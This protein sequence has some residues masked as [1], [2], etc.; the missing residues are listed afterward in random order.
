M[1]KK[2]KRFQIV[3]IT[4]KGDIH[5]GK[6]GC[7]VT[8]A[9]NSP[10]PYRICFKVLSSGLVTNGIYHNGDFELEAT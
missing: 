1:A 10:Y 7:I 4:N 6:R 8:I 5:F 9:K 3:K 2:I